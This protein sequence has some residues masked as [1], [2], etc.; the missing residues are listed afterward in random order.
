MELLQFSLLLTPC[1][2]FL[3]PFTYGLKSTIFRILSP[4][5]SVGFQWG[6]ATCKI[7]VSVWG[8][9]GCDIYLK[10][11]TSYEL[12]WVLRCPYHHQI[13][14]QRASASALSLSNILSYTH[15]ATLT[16]LTMMWAMSPFSQFHRQLSSSLHCSGETL[17]MPWAHTR[18]LATV[19][20]GILGVRVPIVGLIF[21]S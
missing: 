20:V 16:L 8:G 14:R 3:L 9:L 12:I 21:L 4:L 11:V 15:T 17:K 13:L 1:I 6:G 19:T 5:V 7:N 10:L 2:S 18:L